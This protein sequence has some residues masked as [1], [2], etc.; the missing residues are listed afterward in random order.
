M[1][2]PLIKLETEADSVKA[3][4]RI[5]KTAFKQALSFNEVAKAVAPF[6]S[7]GIVTGNKILDDYFAASAAKKN[8]PE[9][10]V[11]AIASQ[12][13]SPFRETQLLNSV[14]RAEWEMQKGKLTGNPSP[15]KLKLAQ[16]KAAAAFT[17]D[18]ATGTAAE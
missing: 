17:P 12:A 13:L 14:L 5:V 2:V 15:R 9:H 4:E 3:S 10:L 11:K 16:K 8:M 1:F 7:N 18:V 6:K